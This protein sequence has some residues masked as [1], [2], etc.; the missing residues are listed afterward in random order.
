MAIMFSSLS[1]P[2][3]QSSHTEYASCANSFAVRCSLSVRLL[4][5]CYLLLRVS[6]EDDVG[7]D[8]APDEGEL[9][10]T[11]GPVEVAYKFRL[12][13]SDLLARRTVERLKPKVVRTGAANRIDDG[14][15]IASK[16]NI[17]IPGPLEF[18]ELEILAGFG[19]DQR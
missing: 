11:K 2:G 15:A 1:L 9:A 8:M 3:A 14:F 18:Q 10:A 12:E 16:A 6:D 13:I 5:V 7:I 4:A 19:G 17:S